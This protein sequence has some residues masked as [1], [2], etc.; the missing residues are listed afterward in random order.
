[1]LVDLLTVACVLHLTLDSS[2]G[3]VTG[4]LAALRRRGKRVFSFS[5]VSRP[6]LEP[7]CYRGVFS[8][9]KADGVWG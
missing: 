8:R 4:L 5:R 2:G 7:T 3:I 9:G 6:S 1:M